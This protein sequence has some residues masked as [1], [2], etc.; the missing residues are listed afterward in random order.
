MAMREVVNWPKLDLNLTINS[1]PKEEPTI[2]SSTFF[3]RTKWKID[4][5]LHFCRKCM[6]VRVLTQWKMRL[7]S[8]IFVCST[9]HYHNRF[10]TECE[11]NEKCVLTL[12]LPCGRAKTFYTPAKTNRWYRESLKNAGWV[13]LA[14]RCDLHWN[15]LAGMR[16]NFQANFF[17]RKQSYSVLIQLLKLIVHFRSNRPMRPNGKDIRRLSNAGSNHDCG[18]LSRVVM[19]RKTDQRVINH[20]NPKVSVDQAQVTQLVD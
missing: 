9:F 4:L 7:E 10:S 14:C 2:A 13:A 8:S 17:V 15:S 6:L 12:F 5:I 3:G 20:K 16:Q 18:S 19:V 1:P 11:Q